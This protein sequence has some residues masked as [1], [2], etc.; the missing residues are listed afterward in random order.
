MKISKQQLRMIINEV[1]GS[2]LTSDISQ[3][4]LRLLQ[5]LLRPAIKSKIINNVEDFLSRATLLIAD[6]PYT[7]LDMV[8]KIDDVA[9]AYVEYKRLGREEARYGVHCRPDPY[10]QQPTYMLT[11]IASSSSFRGGG[12]GQILGFL[13]VCFVNKEGRTVTSDRN[14]SDLAGK[15]LVDALDSIGAQKSESFD[16][17]GWLL[18]S[19]HRALYKNREL[20]TD[21][22]SYHYDDVINTSKSGAKGVR[23]SRKLE[24]EYNK[25]IEFLIKKFF[26]KHKPLTQKLSDD[27]VPSLNLTFGS[28]NH[29]V[30]DIYNRSSFKQFLEKYIDLPTEQLQNDLNADER[31]QGYT[32]ILNSEVINIG[33]EIV[34]VINKSEK[35]NDKVFDKAFDDAQDMFGDEYEKSVTEPGVGYRNIGDQSN[36][37]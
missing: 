6:D 29:P 12:F 23:Q 36:D 25:E 35:Y 31:V 19:M 34:N 9:A 30:A 7:G 3:N 4:A 18:G 16:Y 10:A 37:P 5:T 13:S 27:C 15:A 2:D 22:L 14:T 21:T 33:L 11:R 17:V 8:L 28:K 32:F 24:S 20:N 26:A 1:L